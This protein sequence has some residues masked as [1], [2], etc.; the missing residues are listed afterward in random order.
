ME[1]LSRILKNYRET[2]EDI[3]RKKIQKRGNVMRGRER[4]SKV[5]SQREREKERE[6]E[7]L[8]T[9]DTPQ[10]NSCQAASSVRNLMRA[11]DVGR[12]I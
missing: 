3:S 11:A 10:R 4:E 2:G 7:R 12:F 6:R 9:L 5:K 8:Q 1:N